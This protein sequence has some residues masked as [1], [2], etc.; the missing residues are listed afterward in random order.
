MKL[1]REQM[2]S[3]YHMTLVRQ[4]RVTLLHTVDDVAAVIAWVRNRLLLTVVV[5]LPLPH[6]REGVVSSQHVEVLSFL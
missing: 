3:A 2:R 1:L 5:S 4:L 6:V